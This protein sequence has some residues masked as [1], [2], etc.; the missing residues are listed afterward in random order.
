MLC[1]YECK[2]ASNKDIQ[3]IKIAKD[4]K[5]N[6]LQLDFKGGDVDKKK[7]I[8][9]FEHKLC[10]AKALEKLEIDLTKFELDN[11]CIDSMNIC[12]KEMPNLSHLTMHISETKMWDEQFDRLFN[13]SLKGK[14]SIKNLHLVMENVNMTNSKRK[15]IENL[16]KSLP[17]LNHVHVN[18]QRNQLT[19]NEIRDL[20]DVI[21][22]YPSR[23]LLW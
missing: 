19:E 23:I 14:T 16:V 11:D 13:Q 18:I 3:D 2:L 21:F 10:H 12:F 9:F 17:N 1:N 22:T 7:F 4:N 20:N 15:S 5:I 8:N 6:S